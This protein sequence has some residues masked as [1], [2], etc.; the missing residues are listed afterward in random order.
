MTAC[1]TGCVYGEMT[2]KGRCSTRYVRGA[3][4]VRC[5]RWVAEITVCGRRRRFRSTSYANARF[6]LD[7]MAERYGDMPP[8][9]ANVRETESP[10]A[11]CA[12]PRRALRKTATRIAQNRDAP[13]AKENAARK[14]P[15]TSK[16][17]ESRNVR[18]NESPGG[19]RGCGKE[20]G[21]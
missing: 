16:L 11:H 7:C 2:N 20:G 9:R 18:E 15:G 19:L 4:P 12:K 10:A 1:R 3:R 6:W 14:T 17:R 8:A 21:R 13:C 5:F